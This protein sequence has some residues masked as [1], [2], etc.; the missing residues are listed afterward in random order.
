VPRLHADS[1]GVHPESHRH[2]LLLL[3]R[4]VDPIGRGTGRHHRRRSAAGRHAALAAP[5]NHEGDVTAKLITLDG[6]ARRALER[7]LDQV[8]TAVKITLG[9]KGRNVVLARNVGVPTVTKDGVSI[10][11]ESPR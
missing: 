1:T 4:P 9:S 10:A 2:V 11:S 6:E 8:A 7:G 3:R 5:P